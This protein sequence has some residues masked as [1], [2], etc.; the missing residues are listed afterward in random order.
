MRSSES[1]YSISYYYDGLYCN[2]IPPSQISIYNELN[3]VY[4][5]YIM[6]IRYIYVVYSLMRT[7]IRHNP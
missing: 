7:S 6:Y 1:Q 4:I 2:I 3:L 5:Y